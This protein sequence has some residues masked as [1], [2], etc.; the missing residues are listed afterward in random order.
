LNLC[1]IDVSARVPSVRNTFGVVSS[2]YNLI[3]GS[4]KRHL[5]FEHIQKEAGLKQLT[6]KKL[7]ETRWT[8]RLECLK[9]ILLR[10]NEII[11]T[12]ENMEEP[13]A[14]LLL[15]SIRTFDFVIHL[16]LMTEIYFLTN[17]L[18]KFLQGSNISLTDALGQVN[19]TIDTLKSLRNETE[20]ERLYNEALK[21]CDE[22]GIEPCTKVRQ[23]KI[24]ARLGG[25]VDIRTTL[26]VKDY[27]RVNSY[28]VILDTI[29]TSINNKF[30]ENN[31]RIVV[32]MEKLFLSKDCSMRLNCKS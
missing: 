6:I 28:Y 1:L 8:C 13:D 25:G 27:Y 29:I 5:I 23:K 14:F 19:I 15:N 4:A 7:C 10:Y 21:L 26:N 3:E 22:N 31:I 18:S 17:I 30:H 2:L 9:V 20:F 32:L 12:L 24:P 11:M 16:L